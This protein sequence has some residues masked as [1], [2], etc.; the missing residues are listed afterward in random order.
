MTVRH[1]PTKGLLV[2][3]RF[4]LPANNV[5]RL[6]VPIL[7]GVSSIVF[8]GCSSA[9]TTAEPASSPSTGASATLPV[10]VDTSVAPTVPATIA[11]DSTIAAVESTPV[12]T[13]PAPTVVDPLDDLDEDGEVDASC[14]TADLGG[15]LVVETPCNDALRPTPEVGV[16]PTAQSLLWLPA[17]T[18]LDDLADVDA[19]VRVARTVDGRRVAIYV[20]GSD[21]LFDSGSA[22]LRTTSAAPI[23]AIV[24]SIQRRFPGLPVTVRGAADSVGDPATNQSLSQQRAAAV[25]A[26]LVARGI[27][28]ESL[29]SI[30]L[31]E[32]VPVAEELNADGTV[33]DIGQ[34]VN[35]RV[36][37]VV[38]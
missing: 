5:S 22:T 9:A 36:E 30:G 35:R 25:A 28:G 16:M 27:P 13:D 23:A 10:T 19:T 24:A 3:Q 18:R 34:Q 1:P 31:G 2:T 6:V 21:T 33:S 20:L 32:V 26:D 38:G 7:C 11:L 15:G 8:A 29:T 37:I 4:A 14:G 12:E 17:P